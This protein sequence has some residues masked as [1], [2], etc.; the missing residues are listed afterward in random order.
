[1][2]SRYCAYVRKKVDYLIATLDPAHDD[3]TLPEAELRAHLRESCRTVRLMGLSVLDAMTH[4]DTGEVLFH[5]K[6][7]VSGQNRSF[8][9]RSIF[10]LRAEGWRYRDGELY[11][12]STVPSGITLLSF[13]EHFA[14]VG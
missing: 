9:E 13:R 2:R 1:M 3:R 14:G 5:A 11:L 12:A 8:L 4:G 6:R 10:R 7:F